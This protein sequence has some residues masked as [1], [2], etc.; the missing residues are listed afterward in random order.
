MEYH[1]K[2]IDLSSNIIMFDP[3][4]YIINNCKDQLYDYL[5]EEN[6]AN[7]DTLEKEDWFDEDEVYEY[8][9]SQVKPMMNYFYYVDIGIN[10]L[11]P[12]KTFDLIFHTNCTLIQMD[13][14]DA[15]DSFY[16]GLTGGEMDLSQDIALAYFILTGTIPYEFIDQI[17]LNHPLSVNH[18]NFRIILE[19]CREVLKNTIDKST[20]Q[21]EQI[22][23]HLLKN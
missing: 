3:T 2:Y 10:D 16:I 23:M 12:D 21:I 14:D 18:I 20:N 8:V 1:S 6:L 15:D 19:K 7:E 13:R 4:D 9:R 17:Y 5:K 11:T 22:E